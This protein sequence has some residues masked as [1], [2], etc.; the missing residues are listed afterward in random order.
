MSERRQQPGG[1]KFALLHHGACRQ[2]RFHWR[3]DVRGQCRAELAEAE[4][5]QHPRSIGVVLDGDFDAAPPATAQLEALQ[6]LLLALK[7]RYPAIEV[8]AHRQ[9]RGDAEAT[10]PGRRFPL[11]ALAAWAH[12]ELLQQRD[13]AQQRSVEAQY[14]KPGPG[15][16]ARPADSSPPHRAPPAAARNNPGTNGVK[17]AGQ[18]QGRGRGKAEGAPLQP[19][20]TVVESIAKPG[21]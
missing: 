13:A 17:V 5:G 4:P 8:G 15:I 16:M 1:V 7:L 6:H 9:V 14:A 3:I 10:C 19:S 11:A 12:T 20:E 18:P 21:E 2:G